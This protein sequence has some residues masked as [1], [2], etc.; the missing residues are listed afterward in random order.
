MRFLQARQNVSSATERRYLDRGND[1]MVRGI[2]WVCVDDTDCI[3]DVITDPDFEAVWADCDRDGSTP[4]W[5]GS[6]VHR[7]AH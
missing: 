6:A 5:I 4:T 1:L 3:R 7:S 2:I